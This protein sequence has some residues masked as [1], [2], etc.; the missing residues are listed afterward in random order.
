MREQAMCEPYLPSELGVSSCLCCGDFSVKVLSIAQR[1]G[2]A[3][4][5]ILLEVLTVTTDQLQSMSMTNMS[6]CSSLVYQSTVHCNLH[7]SVRPV[8]SRQAPFPKINL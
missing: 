7:T 1:D 8:L 4:R 6:S 2:Y 5:D 3:V